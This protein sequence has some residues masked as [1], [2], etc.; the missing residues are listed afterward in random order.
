MMASPASRHLD[1]TLSIVAV[2]RNTKPQCSAQAH[3]IYD[4]IATVRTFERPSHAH[5]MLKRMQ[6]SIEALS[7]M[8]QKPPP[9]IHTTLRQL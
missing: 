8:A 2:K 9:H 4:G 7:L 5:T 1:A 3:V 6:C